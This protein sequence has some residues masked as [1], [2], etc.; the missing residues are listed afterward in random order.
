MGVLLSVSIFFDSLNHGDAHSSQ[1]AAAVSASQDA[2]ADVFERIECF[3]SRMETYIEVPPTAG[4]TE[5]IVKIM[6]EVI[7]IIGIATKGMKQSRAKRYVKRLMGRT[8]ME[9][10]L[11]RLDRLTKEEV[12]MA[13]A[14]GLKA[15][16]EVDGKVQGVDDKVQDV[17]KKVQG[18][19]DRVRDVDD[20]IDVVID[21]ADKTREEIL[22]SMGNQDR[23]QIRRDLQHWLLP[24]DSSINYNTACDAHHQGTATWFTESTTFTDWKAS[25]SLLWIHGK[26]GSGKSVLTSSIIRDIKGISDAGS[27]HIS[28]FFFDFKDKGK[29]DVRAL[30]SSL[31]IQLSHQSDSF[32]DILIGHHSTHQSGSQQPSDGTLTQCLEDMLRVPGQVPIY[33]II[34]AL[35]ECPNT[36]GIPTPRDKVLML[37]KKLVES[38]PRNLRLCI[39]SRPEVDIRTSIE[40]LTSNRISLHDESGQKEDIDNFIYSVVYSDQ[41]MRRWRDADK[42]VVVETLSKRADGMF[43]WVFCQLETLRQC[44][45]ASVRVILAELPETLDATYERILSEI[46]K[47]NRVY[48][49]RLLQCLTVAFRPLSVEE[50]AEVLAVDFTPIGGI[51]KLKEDLRWEDQEQAVLTACSSLVAVV[52]HWGLREVQFSHFSVKE[53]LTSDRL[54]TSKMDTSRYHRI[55]LEEAHTIM[56]QAC[57]SV[58]LRLDYDL[59]EESVKSFPLANYAGNHFSDHVEFEDVL[60]QI[61]DG[62]DDLLDA[63]NP[64]FAAWLWIRRGFHHSYILPQQPAARPEDINAVGEYGTLLHV[65]SRG[66]HSEIANFL[67]DH[68]VDVDV[69][70]PDAETP[71]HRAV[72][73]SYDSD[74]GVYSGS[75]EIIRQLIERNADI[76]ARDNEGKTPLHQLLAR[77]HGDACFELVKFLLDHGADADTRDNEASTLLHAAS[78]CGSVK[79]VELLLKNNANTNID[80]KDKRGGTPLHRAMRDDYGSPAD[81]YFDAIPFLLE[82]GADVDA[83]DED[84]STPLH[85]A[86]QF[87]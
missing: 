16:H 3:F 24:P 39:T 27:A 11:R 37:V 62:V 21:G 80:V 71:L 17:D 79:V 8:D 23:N 43:R 75:F 45:P 1:T 61:G 4:M 34:D 48:T 47:S 57:L 84:H 46:P 50:L 31:V 12:R 59:D 63:G 55:R 81:Y 32:C 7:S 33:I 41:N 10:A 40:P 70:D 28:Y 78:A 19:D 25:G 74:R 49:H 60:S 86:V 73:N 82:H 66:G 58:L 68:F 77:G 53:F 6:I 13:A 20:K 76:N 67:L 5:I 30:L 83:L 26:P 35:D 9:D 42:K 22:T 36:T 85:L 65:A 87:G 72:S 2:L 44:L 51:P 38:E 29:Q 15:T 52:E 69:R 64:H 56:A 14:Q 18:V 54:A